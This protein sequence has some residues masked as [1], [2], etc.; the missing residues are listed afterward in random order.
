MMRNGLFLIVV[1]IIFALQIILITFGGIAFGVYGDFGL[2]IHQWLI[3]VKN[4]LFR[5]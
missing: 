3:C 5:L 4:V 1:A 2:T